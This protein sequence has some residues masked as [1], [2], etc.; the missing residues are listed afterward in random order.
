MNKIPDTFFVVYTF[1]YYILIFIKKKLNGGY[2]YL[3]IHYFFIC[4]I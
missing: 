2:L 3:G 4:F 1:H